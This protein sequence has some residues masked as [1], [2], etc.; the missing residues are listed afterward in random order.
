MLFRRPGDLW[1]WAIASFLAVFALVA[2]CR[3]QQAARLGAPVANPVGARLDP[4]QAPIRPIV[5]RGNAA[6][7]VSVD[8][9]AV[10]L[11]LGSALR[12][13]QLGNLDIAQTRAVVDQARAAL[14]R[15]QV[16]W[17][18]NINTG[19]TY[20]HHEGNIQKTEGNIIKVN[21]D[22]L[23]LGTGPS[24]S[25]Q[26]SD[27]IFGP[28]IAG[29]LKAA[30]EASLRTV[31]ND[32]LF[33]V[34]DA[35]FNILRARRRLAR[36]DDTLE[37]LTSERPSLLRADSK[38]LFPLVRDFVE[39]GR[40]E[41][42]KSDLARVDVEVMRRKEEREAALQEFAFARAELA[43]LLALDPTTPLWPAEDFRKPVAIPTDEWLAQSL[44]DLLLFAIQNRP[45]LAQD[46]A[47][48]RAALERVRQAKMR[49][50]LPIFSAGYSWGGFGGGPDLNT[51]IIQPPLTKGGP[52]RV[53]AQAG[54]S[55]S[56]RISN[57]NTRTDFDVGLTWRLQNFG[58]G[59]RAEIREQE[60]A[61]RQALMRQLQSKDRVAAQLVQTHEQILAWQKR[62]AV[63]RLTLFDADQKPVG[64]AYQS[65]R[66]NF[67][68]IRGGEGRPLEVLDSIRSLNDTLE[69]YA[70]AVTE[71]ERT[72]FR[73]LIVLGLP[74][75]RIID[76]FTLP[77]PIPVGKPA[78]GP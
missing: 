18:P 70:Q 77:P 57:F 26:L 39:V 71:Y 36:I 11:T 37:N 69:L 43:R 74:S 25:I 72:R 64:P 58:F 7:I 33:A 3:A 31:S 8:K 21:R 29:Q 59:N 32:A 6:E 54:F 67:D 34:A 23:G 14:T 38:G 4:P 10:P 51:S 12:L 75:P 61:E 27:A 44:D 17:L 40:K 53:T 46:Q 47:L 48:T 15:A 9:E 76:S 68:R 24:M 1:K 66:L 41:A 45:E 42:L 16:G 56:G 19:S 20:S 13:A 30:S 22:S 55:G 62:L 49:P 2:D 52:V 73:L 50:L 28:L 35:Y 60:G 63:T 78:T 5:A 65:V